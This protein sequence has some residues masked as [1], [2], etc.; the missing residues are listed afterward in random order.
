[1]EKI[2]AY[3]MIDE[4]E[5]K[6]SEGGKRNIRYY[7]T[8]ISHDPKRED[9]ERD[10]NLWEM[11]RKAVVRLEKRFKDVQFVAAEHNDH[12]DIRHVHI[13]ALIPGRLRVSDFRMLRGVAEG[14]ALSQRSGRRQAT[15]RRLDRV[16]SRQT[17][18]P[19]SVD[20]GET[21]QH[22]NMSTR[23]TVDMTYV[24]CPRCGWGMAMKR[25]SSSLFRCPS[26][27][28]KFRQTMGLGLQVQ[29]KKQKLSLYL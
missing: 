15:E 17:S 28:T 5:R 9:P 3:R 10:V 1:M 13:L 4:A 14:E 20:R 19:Q 21:R 22:V 6:M 25:L 27:G 2:Q 29:E 23:K 8:V 16:L 24:T 11:T 7:R 18:T 12:T 26:C